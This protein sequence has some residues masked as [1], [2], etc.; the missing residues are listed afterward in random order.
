MTVGAPLNGI[1]N[2]AGPEVLTLDELGRITLE[3]KG[4]RRTVVTDDAAGMFTAMKGDVLIPGDGDDAVIAK[5][6]YREWL[7]SRC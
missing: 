6:T 2:V 4:D 5:T 1:Q 3:A 7:A